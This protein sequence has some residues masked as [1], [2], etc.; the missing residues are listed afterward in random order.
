MSAS[1]GQ[2]L[3]GPPMPRTCG[4]CRAAFPGDPSLSLGLEAGWWAC[5]PCRGTLFGPGGQPADWRVVAVPA[6]AGS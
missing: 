3:A 2:P 4:R 5:D 1:H 6:G